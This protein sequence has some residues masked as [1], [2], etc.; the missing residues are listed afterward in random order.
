MLNQQML[1]DW[2]VGREHALDGYLVPIPEQ[3]ANWAPIAKLFSWPKGQVVPPENPGNLPER[4]VPTFKLDD[5][6]QY[7]LTKHTVRSG[8]GE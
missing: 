2:T 8:A 7:L 3:T 5:G 6:S 4:T 1:A